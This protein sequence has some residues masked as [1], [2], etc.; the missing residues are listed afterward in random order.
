MELLLLANLLADA[1][2]QLGSTRGYVSIGTIGISQGFTD[3][4]IGTVSAG[5]CSHVDLFAIIELGVEAVE[6]GI[7]P[8]G[9]ATVIESSLQVGIGKI[10]WFGH[11][12]TAVF[13][14]KL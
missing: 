4:A 2:V 10:I 7:D 1:G 5:D 8:D 12:E 9:R 11:S 13:S 14:A 3:L 6:V